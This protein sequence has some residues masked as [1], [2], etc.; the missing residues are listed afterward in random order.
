MVGKATSGNVRMSSVV[1]GMA[2]SLQF[3]SNSLLPYGLS[4]TRLH[5]PWNFPVKST[6]MGCHSLLRG[7]EPMSPASPAMAGGFFHTEP[8]GK[9]PNGNM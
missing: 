6:E 7:I 2:K 3:L 8:P 5:C 4:P 1:V 9:P